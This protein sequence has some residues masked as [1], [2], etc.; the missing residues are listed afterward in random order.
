MKLIRRD[1][2]VKRIIER[3][4]LPET[5]IWRVFDAVFEEI[6]RALARGEVVHIIRFGTFDLRHYPK[7][8]GVHPRTLE[9]IPY[10]TRIAPSFRSS[11]ALKRAI[12]RWV[13]EEGVTPEEL[14]AFHLERIRRRTRRKAEVQAAEP[15]TEPAP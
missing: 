1:E 15:A 7:R 5:T 2:L 14:A 13:E 10:P 9:Q 12:R 4:R 6:G 3:T 8:M 11:A